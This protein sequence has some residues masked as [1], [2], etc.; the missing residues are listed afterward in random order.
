MTQKPTRKQFL[1]VLIPTERVWEKGLSIYESSELEWPSLAEAEIL[2]GEEVH[3]V[4]PSS[5][6]FDMNK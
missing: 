1:E 4:H 5:M 3:I 2:V 6:G